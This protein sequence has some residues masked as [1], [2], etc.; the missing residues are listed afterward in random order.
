MIKKF[1]STPKTFISITSPSFVILELFKIFT[2]K[3][4]INNA[5]E[6]DTEVISMSL[7]DLLKVEKPTGTKTLVKNYPNLNYQRLLHYLITWKRLELLKLDWVR[8]KFGIEEIKIRRSR[9]KSKL[10]INVS[11]MLYRTGS[12][13]F[14]NLKKE[15]F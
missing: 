14:N 13:R 5:T 11:K 1:S 15:L 9:Q 12:I 4:S 8:S 6:D 2:S 7:D 10:K 3:K